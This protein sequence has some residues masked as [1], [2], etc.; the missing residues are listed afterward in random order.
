MA[1]LV[2]PILSC[3][4]EKQ[5]F[6]YCNAMNDFTRSEDPYFL[7]DAANRSLIDMLTGSD[8]KLAAIAQHRQPRD[9]D[10]VLDKARVEHLLATVG[11]PTAPDHVR[12][13][14][15]AWLSYADLDKLGLADQLAQLAGNADAEVR[16]WVPA[17]VP[18]NHPTAAEVGLVGKLLRDD[19]ETVVGDAAQALS[20]F[21][22]S[23]KACVPLEDAVKRS[24]AK[25]A[26]VITS[27]GQAN[28][29]DLQKMVIDYV[30]KKTRNPSK[31]TKATGPDWAVAVGAAC[32]HVGNAQ[33][34][35]GFA[36]AVRMTL[37]SDPVPFARVDAIPVLARCDQKGSKAAMRVIA[38]LA[39]D[40]DKDVSQAAKDELGSLQSK[41]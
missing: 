9:A 39:K 41:E 22:P 3:Q 7:T 17:M 31:I 18:M 33:K 10:K 27:V 24:D 5:D 16:K 19:N 14:A 37:P 32:D 2:K 40:K 21:P 34:R 4:F 15:V 13:T 23:A 36:V 12:K 11:R 1:A 29:K 8:E 28:C 30:D 20:A 25:A 38:K 6:K 35:K 26:K